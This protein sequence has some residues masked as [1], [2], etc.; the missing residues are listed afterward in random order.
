MG[1]LSGCCKRLFSKGSTQA[2]GVLTPACP[3]FNSGQRIC[4]MQGLDG[5]RPHGKFPVEV[6]W[7]TLRNSRLIFS[8]QSKWA[9]A[10][11][12]AVAQHASS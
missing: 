8:L 2:T 4:C 5:C 12:Q 1:I 9:K 6:L 3:R 11:L 10:S 7:A